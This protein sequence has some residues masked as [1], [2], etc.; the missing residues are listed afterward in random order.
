MPRKIHQRAASGKNEQE[1]MGGIG[2]RGRHGQDRQ[3]EEDGRRTA[4]Q[5]PP[6]PPTP[7]NH[8]NC[9]SWAH[10]WLPPDNPR[11]PTT[12]QTRAKWRVQLAWL[13]QWQATAP[14]PANPTSIE[15]P[16]GTDVLALHQHLQKPESS[17]AVQLRTGKNCFNAFL[18][19]ARVP[20]VP[21]PLCSCGRGSQ[22]AK[23]ILIHCSTFSA[24]RHQLR[25]NQGR[26][27]DY[28]QLLTTPEGL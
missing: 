3:E 12:L 18:Y 16:P 4:T 27:P 13:Q 23:H 10:H 25:D 1:G 15:A 9:L 20:T 8:P 26:L 5:G 22:T 7:I 19:Q 2:E 24:T 14:Y 11:R 21:S 6:Q 17:L 28:K